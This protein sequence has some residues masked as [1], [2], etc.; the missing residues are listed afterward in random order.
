MLVANDAA[1]SV[2][3]QAARSSRTMQTNRSGPVTRDQATA[4]DR[5]EDAIRSNVITSLADLSDGTGGFLVANSNDLK[6][7]LRRVTEDI[8]THYEISY[9]P[10]IDKFDGHFRKIS[11][12]VDR[13]DTRLQTRS[14]YFA[15]PFTAGRQVNTWELPMLSA[16][17]AAPPPRNIP[18]RSS[19]LR[20][21]TPETT[22]SCCASCQEA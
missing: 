7:Q 20:F 22:R 5:S 14:G 13:A 11:V 15:L 12:K 16:I 9:S 6:G 18:Y 17:A 4:G 8:D 21:Q 3:G 10:A 2:L 1:D 19:S